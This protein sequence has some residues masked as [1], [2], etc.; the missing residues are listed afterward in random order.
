[1]TIWGVSMPLVGFPLDRM[2]G[3]ILV[4]QLGLFSTV[5][6]S[7][8]ILRDRAD[9]AAQAAQTTAVLL[10]EHATR[11]IIGGALIVA[12]GYAILCLSPWAGL[13]VIA[14]VFMPIGEDIP[15]YWNRI[16]LVCGL[17][18]LAEC[19]TLYATGHTQGLWLQI[20][21]DAR[22]WLIG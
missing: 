4:G 6:E 3:W 7:I 14:C 22:L 12:G 5:F 19:A 10:G 8:Q 13:A 16:R 1:M 17:A 9:D 11:R 2:A 20:P 21:A 15:R 18:F